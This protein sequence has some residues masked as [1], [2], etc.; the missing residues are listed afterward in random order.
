M[1]NNKYIYMGVT[2]GDKLPLGHPNAVEHECFNYPSHYD[3]LDTQSTYHF[4]KWADDSNYPGT[5]TNLSFRGKCI[6][7]LASEILPYRGEDGHTN[8]I[9]D[10]RL[11]HNSYFYNKMGI[12][13]FDHVGARQLVDPEKHPTLQKITDWFEFDGYANPY[14]LEKRPGQWEIWHVDGHF[15]SENSGDAPLRILIHLQDWEFGQMLLWGT[16]TI[17]Q[18]RAGD[19]VWY[20]P[21]IPHATANSSRYKRYTLR[22][23][24]IPSKNTLQKLEKGGI[25]N[26]DEL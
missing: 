26:V 24:G 22:L 2:D 8:Y 7:N 23:T 14:I 17:I 20:D 18:W 11:M 16:K 4:D 13:S 19:L 21:N 3:Y 10:V 15:K 25:I 6:D 5:H 12:G 1:S 9:N